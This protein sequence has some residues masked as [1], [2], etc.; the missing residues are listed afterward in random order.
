[1]GGTQG[2]GLSFPEAP[3]PINHH[4]L[5]AFSLIFLAPTPP[6]G[7][8]LSLGGCLATLSAILPVVSPSLHPSQDLQLRSHSLATVRA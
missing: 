1:M 2:K 8:V 3:V 7:V 4:A 6:F 5:A